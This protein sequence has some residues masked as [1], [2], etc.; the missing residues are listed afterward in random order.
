MTTRPTDHAHRCQH[1]TVIQRCDQ[2]ATHQF[3]VNG[4]PAT[5][6]G[7][8]CQPHGEAVIAEYATAVEIVGVWTM[9]AL[10]N[11]QPAD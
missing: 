7:Y 5:F 2:P 6:A 1:H 8:T 4:V 11:D 9:E 3:L 10:P